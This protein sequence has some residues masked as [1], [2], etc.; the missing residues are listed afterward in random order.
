MQTK[1]IKSYLDKHNRKKIGITCKTFENIFEDDI[2][3]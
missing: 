1:V 3:R 2:N